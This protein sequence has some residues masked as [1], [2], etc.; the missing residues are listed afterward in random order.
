M[1]LLDQARAAAGA[2]ADAAAEGQQYKTTVNK[3]SRNMTV[4]AATL[5][6]EW[7]NGWR[8]HTIFEQGGNTVCVFER[9]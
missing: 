9:R 2:V 4:L 7:G 8:L 5:N 6:G 1:G 3:G